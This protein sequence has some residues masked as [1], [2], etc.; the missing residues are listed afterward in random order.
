MQPLNAA[1]FRNVDQPVTL[2]AANAV[3]TQTAPVT[4]TFEIATDAAFTTKV[5]TKD[6]VAEGANGQTSVRLDLLPPA[7]DYYWH[8][9]ATGGGT[10][11]VFGPAS[12]FTIGAAVTVS[13]PVAIAPLT[14][15]ETGARP[16]FR[17][18]NAVRTGFAGAIT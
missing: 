8:A 11:G 4:Y 12:K 13:A 6:N 15:A 1:Q 14:G 3:I 10:T 18:R 2:L 9:R 17:V 16:T 7:A 5:Q